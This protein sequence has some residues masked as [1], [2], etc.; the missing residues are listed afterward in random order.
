MPVQ[1]RLCILTFSGKE[2]E[3]MGRGGR[4]TVLGILVAEVMLMG[5][6]APVIYGVY[7]VYDLGNHQVIVL[8]ILETPENV[9]KTSTAIAEERNFKITKRDDKEMLITGITKRGL[10]ATAK[11]AGMPKGGSRFTITA[12]KGKDPKAEREEMVNTVLAVCSKFGTQCA[13]EKEK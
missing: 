12:E 10:E 5:C 1:K 3:M 2:R 4:K 8:S 9:Y 6:F 7:K 13:E 11:I